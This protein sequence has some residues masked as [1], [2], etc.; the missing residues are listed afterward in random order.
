MQAVIVV[1]SQP[2]DGC[3]VAAAPVAGGSTSAFVSQLIADALPIGG[4]ECLRDWY[5]TRGPIDFP[6]RPILSRSWWTFV[7]RAPLW[8]DIWRYH[9]KYKYGPIN[10]SGLYRTV[11]CD[12]DWLLRPHACLSVFLSDP[13]LRVVFRV[14]LEQVSFDISNGFSFV[15]LNA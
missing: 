13:G 14:T 7:P 6:F 11:S 1:L 12:Y 2:A 15:P 8:Y 9:R 10:R 5:A 4:V 3:V